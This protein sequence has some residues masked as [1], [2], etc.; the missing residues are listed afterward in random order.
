MP[1]RF[2]T[3]RVSKSDAALEAP[4]RRAKE[5]VDGLRDAFLSLDAQWRITGSNPSAETILRRS[6]EDLLGCKIW[7]VIGI[8]PDSALGAVVRR[9]KSSGQPEESEVTVEIEGAE[10]Q[11]IVRSFPLA[12]GISITAG[13]LTELRA[14]ARR[15]AEGE[16][17]FR[18]LA[19]IAPVATWA[20]RADGVIEHASP[21]LLDGLRLDDAEI[22]GRRWEL[23]I[24]PEDSG[25]FGEAVRRSRIVHAPLLC[26]TRVRRGDGAVRTLQLNGFPRFDAGGRFNGYIGMATDVTDHLAAEGRR[27]LL[28]NELNHRVKNSLATVQSIVR[29]T[30][31]GSLVGQDT[32]D[33]LTERLMALAAAHDLLTQENWQSIE[34]SD[35]AARALHPF[36]PDQTS[37]SLSGPPV[38]LHPGA[39]LALF[40]AINELAGNAVRYGALSAPEGRVGLGWTMLDGALDLEWREHGGPSVDLPKHKGFGARLL[41][42]GL[43]AELGAS[44]QLTF[45]PAGLRCR[46][47]AAG[48]GVIALNPDQSRG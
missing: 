46:I 4:D 42:A 48:E 18:D 6:S 27:Q 37:I 15:L 17:R 8:S 28:V 35:M 3:P 31:R 10:R 7:Q 14:V 47:R 32:I 45:A 44:A 22:I 26:R 12:G 21:A 41:D 24:P 20:T 33:L 23:H 43:R 36:D 29:Q 25:A 30:L 16:S 38:W 2:E 5:I 39:A 19:L 40:I 9:V 11:L 13:D 34:L 1:R